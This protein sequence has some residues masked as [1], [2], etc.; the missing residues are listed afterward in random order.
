MGMGNGIGGTGIGKRGT[1]NGDRKTRNGERRF[2][3]LKSSQQNC[4]KK[5]RKRDHPVSIDK[6]LCN[7]FQ[8]AHMF[9]LSRKFDNQ[10]C[11]DI[12]IDIECRISAL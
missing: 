10:N 5:R 9:Y 2:V 12:D 7:G 6:Q 3:Y 11:F 4:K 1:G 8:T